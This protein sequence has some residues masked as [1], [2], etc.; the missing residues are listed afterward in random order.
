MLVTRSHRLASQIA[1]P[2]QHIGAT[3]ENAGFCSWGDGRQR[4]KI[5]VCDCWL[6]GRAHKTHKT[7]YRNHTLRSHVAIRVTREAWALMREMCSCSSEALVSLVPGEVQGL[8]ETCRETGHRFLH[9]RPPR[10]AWA[11]ICRQQRA[12]ASVRRSRWHDSLVNCHCH[13]RSPSCPWACQCTGRAGVS[14]P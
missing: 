2:T 14:R 6:D 10:G 7:L 3:G 9:R 13:H 11:W 12:K 4:D 8:R 5:L 1:S